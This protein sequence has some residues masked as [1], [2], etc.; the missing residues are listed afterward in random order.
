VIQNGLRV[1]GNVE[2][3]AG[4]ALDV[5]IADDHGTVIGLARTLAAESEG[6]RFTSLLG[7]A[8]TTSPDILRFYWLD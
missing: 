5:L 8:R 2:A 6:H 1:S 7:Y 3:N 4:R